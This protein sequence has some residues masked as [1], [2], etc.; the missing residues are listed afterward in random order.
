M[1]ISISINVADLHDSI[2]VTKEEFYEPNIKEIEHTLSAEIIQPNDLF[3]KERYDTDR[4]LTVYDGA[5]IFKIKL[6]KLFPRKETL[7]KDLDRY[8]ER[9]YMIFDMNLLPERHRKTIEEIKFVLD[10]I[11]KEGLK[12]AKTAS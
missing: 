5:D 12:Y 4:E 8:R 2:F 6:S 7:E 11:P 10:N 3:L 9:G 1:K